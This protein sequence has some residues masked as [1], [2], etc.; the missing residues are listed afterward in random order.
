[1][2]QTVKTFTHRY[3]GE[4]GPVDEQMNSYLEEHPNA[5][6]SQLSYV[7]GGNFEKVVVVFDIREET[8]GSGCSPREKNRDKGKTRDHHNMVGNDEAS[9]KLDFGEPRVDRNLS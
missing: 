8:D 1:M 4:G 2:K 7:L 3:H 5:K 9:N 6:V